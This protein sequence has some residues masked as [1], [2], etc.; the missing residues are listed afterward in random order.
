MTPSLRKVDFFLLYR[1]VPPEVIAEGAKLYKDMI[2]DLKAGVKSL[3]IAEGL[4]NVAK[5]LAALNIHMEDKQ[6]K[7][8]DV[9]I[10]VNTDCL[11]AV[12]AAK[13]VVTKLKNICDLVLV[14]LRKGK[15]QDMMNGAIK[16]FVQESKTMEKPV[17]DAIVLLTK[18]STSSVK[19]K[20]HSYTIHLVL[21]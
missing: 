4:T 12:D 15:N 18:A 6:K 14:F 16:A 19:R 20:F 9:I 2:N 3:F 1:A 8:L 5:S 21:K 13:V 11:L 10:K 7:S 17:G